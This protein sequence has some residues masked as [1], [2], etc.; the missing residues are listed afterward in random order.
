[1]KNEN[2]NPAQLDEETKSENILRTN[3]SWRFFGAGK[4]KEKL[5]ILL[6]AAKSRGDSLDHALF[7]DLRA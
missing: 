1:M 5:S 2:L 3:F 4:L 6:K 7:Y